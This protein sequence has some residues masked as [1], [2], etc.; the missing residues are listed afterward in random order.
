MCGFYCIVLIEYM[1]AGKNVSVYANL[2]SPNDYKG[3]EK[4][5]N[6]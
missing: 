1:L 5:I 3:N 2:L 4:I 6:K